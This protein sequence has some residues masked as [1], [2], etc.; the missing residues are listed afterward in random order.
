MPN[1]PADDRPRKK[2]P[3]RGGSRRQGPPRRNG[4][5][6]SSPHQPRHGGGRSGQARGGRLSR[7]EIEW[8]RDLWRHGEPPDEIA[9][10]LGIEIDQ[11]EQL[12]AG[13]S[14]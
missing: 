14:K 1:N 13:W 2:G 8:A 12:I 11:V 4:A 10:Q 9:N 7:E 3:P 6:D 5:P